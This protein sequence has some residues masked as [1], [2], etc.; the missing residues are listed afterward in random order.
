MNN[1]LTVMWRQTIELVYI[2]TNKQSVERIFKQIESVIV[3]IIDL[4]KRVNSKE[5]AKQYKCPSGIN[6]ICEGM[7]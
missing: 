3:Y 5:S 7:Y 2:P 4:E 1:C 6:D